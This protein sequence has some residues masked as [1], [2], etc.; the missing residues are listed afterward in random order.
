M[1]SRQAADQL[2]AADPQLTR[3]EHA[4]LRR[5]VIARYGQ[6]LQLGDVG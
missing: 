2:I 1:Q 5:Q 3:A 6:V 4:G